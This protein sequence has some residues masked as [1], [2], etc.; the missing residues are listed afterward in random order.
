MIT[1]K[2]FNIYKKNW[3]LEPLRWGNKKE[4]AI[5][6]SFPD[7]GELVTDLYLL[8]NDQLSDDYKNRVLEKLD[9]L[10]F[11]P[12]VKEQFIEYA[13]GYGERQTRS[14][15]QLKKM[16]SRSWIWKLLGINR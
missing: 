2:Q 3:G 1:A 15:Q 5:M 7:V 8:Y 10:E 4:Q 16:G 12:G 13:K 9:K 14:N 11:E 6:E